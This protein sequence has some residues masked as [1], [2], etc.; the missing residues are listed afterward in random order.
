MISIQKLKS[1]LWVLILFQFV[2]MVSVFNANLADLPSHDRE[3][4]RDASADVGIHH[5]LL[6]DVELSRKQEEVTFLEIKNDEAPTQHKQTPSSSIIG[7]IGKSLMVIAACPKFDVQKAVVWSQLECFAEKV[8]QI[9][10]A[11]DHQYKAQ[12]VAFVNEVKKNMPQIGAKLKA[13][14]YTNDRYDAGLWCDT[15]IQG[16]ILNHESRN[17]S[18]PTSK[19]ASQP[20]IAKQSQYDRFILINDSMMALDKS[21]ELLDALEAKNVSFVS[22]N[23]WGKKT[24]TDLGDFWLESPAR[25]FNREGLEIFANNICTVPSITKDNWKE[26]CPHIKKLKMKPWMKLKKCVVEKTET[27]LTKF[28]PVD[29][30]HGLYLGSDPGDLSWSFNFTF[31]T[32]LRDRN[33]FPVVKRKMLNKLIQKGRSDEIGR[34]TKSMKRW[35]ITGKKELV[36]VPHH[37]VMKE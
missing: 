2:Y 7:T 25:A 27:S 22:L 12:M 18:S 29:K 31:W 11:A 1:L 30:V 33:S 26:F 28:Y 19:T 20:Y 34:C 37:L 8:D 35:K 3:L 4:W 9:I 15:L 16:N 23:Y 36:G 6:P 24:A 5:Q 21:N 13:E 17:S 10:I 14:F 32:E